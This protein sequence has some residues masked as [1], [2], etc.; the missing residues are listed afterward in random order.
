MTKSFDC[1]ELQHQGGER[2]TRR[3]AG[4]TTGEKVAYWQ[5]RTRL[6]RA[7]QAAARLRGASPESWES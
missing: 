2:V 1:V 5:E 4:M 6:L 7:R 3:L